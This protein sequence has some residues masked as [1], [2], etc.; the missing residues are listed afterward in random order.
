MA[1]VDTDCLDGRVVGVSE[2]LKVIGND[3]LHGAILLVREAIK[4]L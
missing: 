4:N 2:R 3:A 1:V